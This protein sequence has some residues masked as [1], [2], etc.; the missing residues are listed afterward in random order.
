MRQ[1]AEPG[2][3]FDRLQQNPQ[4]YQGKTVI[5]G[6]VIVALEHGNDGTLLE[7][8]QTRMDWMGEPVDLDVSA[9]RFLG[10]YEGFLDE[11]I[12][13]KGRKVTIAGEVQG[14]RVRDLGQLSYR[15]PFLTVREIHLWK[16]ESD[17]RYLYP[18][19]YPYPYGGYGHPFRTPYP[20]PY[21]PYG[22]YGY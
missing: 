3:R 8:Y 15:Y 17:S 4:A 7:V 18:Y 12:Y 20:S 9:G 10:L 5:L 21:L 11:E 16:K 19:P 14:E 13:S 2:L 22:P 1:A 6:G